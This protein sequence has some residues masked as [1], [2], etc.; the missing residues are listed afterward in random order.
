MQKWLPLYYSFVRITN[1]LTNLIFETKTVRNF[2][3]QIEVGE[4]ILKSNKR[5]I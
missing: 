1:S 3:F 5:I 4:A 2:V